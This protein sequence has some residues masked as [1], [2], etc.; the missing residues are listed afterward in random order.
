MEVGRAFDDNGV[1]LGRQQPLVARQAAEGRF[2]GHAQPLGR[3]LGTVGEIVG[4]GD[5]LVAAVLLEQ[6]GDPVAPAAAA[7]QAQGDLGIRLRPAP[8]PA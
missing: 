2:C 3:G 4:R 6:I 8:I 1:R 7:D 5:E